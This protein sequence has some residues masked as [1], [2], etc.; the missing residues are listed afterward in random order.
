MSGSLA[1]AG[2]RQGQISVVESQVLRSLSAPDIIHDHPQLDRDN[3]HVCHH[4]R[5]LMREASTDDFIL[6][7]MPHFIAVNY[8]RLL[9]EQNPQERVNLTLHIYNLGLRALT[10]NLVNQYLIRDR[11]RV[12]DP[13]LNNLLSKEFPHLTL[14][15]WRRI[16]FATL[17]AYEGK[18]DLF[19]I[20]ELYDFYWDSAPERHRRRTEVEHPFERLTQISSEHKAG[21][22]AQY[23][24]ADWKRLAA[25][26]L[27]LLRQVMSGLGFFEHYDLIRVLAFDE[28]SYEYDL[29][30][31]TTI[32]RERRPQP[33]STDF[34]AGWFYLRNQADDF[35]HL[36][37]LLV[38]WEQEPI[39]SEI[40]QGD[41]GIYDRFVYQE[42]QYLLAN[43]RKPVRD[44]TGVTA[45]M[46]LLFDTIEEVKR[47]RREMERLTWWELCDICAELTTK[48]TETV[49]RKY[50]SDLYL[51][52]D[53]VD[54]AFERFL[55]SDKRC[56]VLIGKSG[57]GKS[58]F[59]LATEQ[60]LRQTRGDD[61]CVLMYDGAQV[62]GDRSISR[63][64]A[65]DF[66]HKL[67]RAGRKIEDIWQEIGQIE[68]IDER[69]VLLFVDA[70][71][72]NP[73]ATELLRQLD[74][75]ALDWPWLKVAFSSR[76]E[77]WKAIK[78][79]V[80]L[81]EGL[82]FREEGAE[83]VG[84][85]IEPFSYSEQM[86]P[87]SRQELP[88]A[89]AKYRQVFHLQT[90]YEQIP[91]ALREMLC[92]PLNLWLVAKTY[93]D[94]AVPGALKVTRLIAEY[95]QM[96]EK[97]ER[98]HLED[99]RLLERRLLPLMM[100]EDDPRNVIT[101][102]DIDDTLYELLY[103]EQPFSDG[104]QMNQSFVNL[105]D[106]EI[107]VRQEE[108]RE[109]KIAFK[110]E[111]IYEYFGGMRILEIGAQ[112]TDRY[113]FFA[114]MVG[115]IAKKTFLWGA[116]GNALIQDV[117][118]T[119]DRG[120]DTIR[121]LCFTDNQRIKELMVYVLTELGRDDRAGVERI[122]ATLLPPQVPINGMQRLRQ[123]FSNTDIPLEVPS[124]YAGEVAVETAY[125][126]KMPAILQ[127]AAL[128]TE[129]T[130]R[131]TAIRFLSYLWNDDQDLGFE[132]LENLANKLVGGLIPIFTV[133]ESVFGLSLI[134]FFENYRDPTVTKRLQNI[135]RR[136]IDGV[137]GIQSSRGFL[138][139]A[140]QSFVR[141]RLFSALVLLI[142]RWLQS[143]PSNNIVNYP[144]LQAFF[145]LSPGQK[146]LYARLVQYFDISGDYSKAQMQ[147]DFMASL[148]INSLLVEGVTLMGMIA[149]ALHDPVDS[150]AFLK[151]FFEA[152]R[153]D[154][155]PN[156]YVS[157]VPLVLTSMLDDD[158]QND[159]CFAFFV[160]TCEVCQEYY[161][162]TPRVQGMYYEFQA[163]ATLQFSPYI[164]HQYRRTRNVKTEW[165]QTRIQ[166][167][168]S[169]KDVTF[170]KKLIEQ[171][172]HQ[173]G[174]QLRQPIPTL[175]TLAL[176]FNSSNAEINKLNRLFLSDL[177]IHYPDEVDDFLEEHHASED[178][179]LQ[180]RTNAPNE[181]IGA[182]VGMRAWHFLRDGFVNSDT[183]RPHLRRMFLS[184]MD[185]K[186]AR[187]WGGYFMREVVNMVYGGEALHQKM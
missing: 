111:R 3:R 50:R 87:F 99:L 160:H 82:Y 117:Q 58:N 19:F 146:A 59:F 171:E 85:E 62:R 148:Q 36:Y 104:R 41:T 142:F 132:V 11:D 67:S 89:Y 119:P 27:D 13:H 180:V 81:N 65:D 16:L 185:C 116:V 14:F 48:R 126:L 168:L 172:L 56:F 174:I 107:L 75:L 79:G 164:I 54:H 34:H 25:E 152:A 121:K 8:L 159:D 137:L 49:R 93:H 78:R 139:N 17:S 138:K 91:N 136:I 169:K 96:L 109:Q 151:T 53:K 141:E 106:A 2:P 170:F 84:I 128:Q 71:N 150:L 156:V 40:I 35:A 158:P 28:T 33:D 102:R 21:T 90:S 72:E 115:K 77:T 12:N 100:P 130:I 31:G 163:P 186:N 55:E 39:A 63:M 86:D 108:G 37:P 176:F 20:P 113:A 26:T 182:L 70:I 125:N 178:F 30:K 47:Q 144:D 5:L 51:Q 95:I 181:T 155:Q 80:K 32:K 73:Q 122:L 123:L 175:D 68:G 92:D 45:Y 66:D 6:A 74:T 166:K 129:P 101:L 183:M 140:F 165:L 145:S 52:R 61:I 98:L 147:Q 103:S 97:S 4:A 120:S 173:A 64:V 143:F 105:V 9:E 114:A 83:T 118:Q 149:Q 23:D 162:R 154:P 124:R 187:E 7:K 42:V 153:A 88:F 44:D 43:I 135:W 60:H 110:Y 134:I 69:R 184:A 167:A 157:V 1:G 133:F 10:I 127:S 24:T 46:Q 177:R 112:H 57:V 179:K 131:L 29:H 161:T 22:F 76:P 38:F 18:R 15:A 94:Q